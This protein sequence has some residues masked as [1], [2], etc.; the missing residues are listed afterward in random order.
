MTDTPEPTESPPSIE[1][2]PSIERYHYFMQWVSARPELHS[3]GRAAQIIA[4]E[5]THGRMS[6]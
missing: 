3:A 2:P 1:P 4:Y 5:N 6:T